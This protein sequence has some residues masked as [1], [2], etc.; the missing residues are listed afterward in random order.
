MKPIT[1]T[2]CGSEYRLSD[3]DKAIEIVVVTLMAVPVVFG[4]LV[5]PLW[6]VLLATGAFLVGMYAL[7][8]YL[9]PLVNTKDDRRRDII[10]LT[11]LF[12]ITATIV[13]VAIAALIRSIQHAA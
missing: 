10:L 8:G 13:G 6:V 5:L 4:F 9:F 2:G 3:W 11:G 12:V 7:L 1:C